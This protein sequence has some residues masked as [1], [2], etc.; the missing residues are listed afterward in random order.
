MSDIKDAKER[1]FSNIKIL[2]SERPVRSRRARGTKWYPKYMVLK[3]LVKR[4]GIRGNG[5][6]KSKVHSIR[7]H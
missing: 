5:R 6:R 7:W 1:K 3:E 2:E 4:E